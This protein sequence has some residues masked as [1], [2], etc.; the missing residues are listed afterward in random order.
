VVCFGFTGAPVKGAAEQSRTYRFAGFELDLR[1]GELLKQG[2]RLRLQEQPFQ[3][4]RL[5]LENAGEVV[6]REELRQKLWP[7]DTFVDFDHGLNNAV[8]RLRDLLDDSSDKPRY[9]ETLPRR[10]YRFIAPVEANGGE[11]LPGS[12]DANSPPASQEVRGVHDRSLATH[13]RLL[14]PVGGLAIAA[15][16]L[17]GFARSRTRTADPITD[18]RVRSLAVLP[19]ENLSG[20]PS[21]KYF[22]EGMTDALITELAQISSVRV[23]SRISIT[24]QDLAGK[25][26][27]EIAREL[28]VDA[29]VEGTVVRSAD[30]VRITVQLIHAPSDRHLWAHSYESD[31][32]DVLALQDEVARDVT[33]QIRA[34]LTMQEQARLARSRP[35]NPGAY[36]L[37]LRGRFHFYERDRKNLDAAIDL[38]EQSV[39]LGPNFAPSHAFLAH[40]YN[41]KAFSFEREDKHLLQLASDQLEAAL[42]LD[43]DLAEAHFARAGLLWTHSNHFPHEQVVHELRRAL[44][45]NPNLAEA[46]HQLG[47]TYNHIGLL[48]QAADELHKAL[49]ID[50]GLGGAHFRMGINLLSQ[51]KYEPALADF[52]GTQRFMPTMWTFWTSLALFHLGRK[53]EASALVD[54]FLKREP[55]DEGG[56]ATAMQAMLLADEGKKGEAERTIQ[57]A[58]KRGEGFGHFHHTAYAIGSAYALMNNREQ[59]IRWLRSA[60]EDGF[61]CYPMFQNDSTLDSLRSDPRFISFMAELKKQWEHYKAVL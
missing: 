44:E 21:Q 22:A 35:V 42:A 27:P 39:K 32:R 34:K 36:D 49:T 1:S 33:Q 2:R 43:P 40:A 10:G 11:Q 28:N 9:I 46:H 41:G 54:S 53:Q 45:L 8:N 60:A 29:L 58:I 5:L 57:A 24:Q 18:L 19:L 3:V 59:A 31:L 50:P 30:R 47:A 12:T 16:V 61:P 14:I 56:V 15:V 13:W 48:D 38:F 23:P 4:L 7:G 55:N 20:D 6:T 52:N 26:L 25:P 37:Y 51:G 17:L